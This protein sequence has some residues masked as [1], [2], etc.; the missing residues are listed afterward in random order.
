MLFIIVLFIWHSVAMF[1]YYCILISVA[2][3][4]LYIFVLELIA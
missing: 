1:V 3:F 2:M 4:C